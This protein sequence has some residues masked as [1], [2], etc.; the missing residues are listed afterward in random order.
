MSDCKDWS[1]D[2]AAPSP[3][4]VWR[5]RRSAI[6]DTNP[7]KL[8]RPVDLGSG[9]RNALPICRAKASFEA[10]HLV[11]RRVPLQPLARMIAPPVRMGRSEQFCF[12]LIQHTHGYGQTVR[13]LGNLSG[14]RGLNNEKLPGLKLM[15]NDEK[16]PK[17]REVED[18]MV[19][20]PAEEGRPPKPATEP[21]TRS[22][23]E[24]QK[25]A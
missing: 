21:A 7:A 16:R 15:P 12:A 23:D 6:V 10:A 25:P 5:Q 4:T 14:R 3:D 19:H 8:A 24:D 1:G 2:P 18:E 20:R 13:H 17:N 9:E 11:G 22:D